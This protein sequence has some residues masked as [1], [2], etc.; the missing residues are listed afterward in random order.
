VDPLDH[1]LTEACPKTLSIEWADASMLPACEFRG[2]SPLMSPC[3]RLCSQPWP[4][5]VP[6]GATILNRA[7]RVVGAAAAL[8]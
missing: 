1:Q 8:A 2:K 3:S 4:C 5:V 6:A 7:P